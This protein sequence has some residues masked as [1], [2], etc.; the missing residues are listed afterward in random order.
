MSERFPTDNELQ[1]AWNDYL[2]ARQVAER[3]GL[4]ADGIVAGKMWRRFIYLF[5]DPEKAAEDHAVVR[6]SDARREREA[7]R[8]LRGKPL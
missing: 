3:S 6:L 1:T 4:I 2:E 8:Q 5:A 7:A